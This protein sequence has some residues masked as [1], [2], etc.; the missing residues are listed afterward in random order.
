MKKASCFEQKNYSFLE[1]LGL[2][3]VFIAAVSFVVYSTYLSVVGTLVNSGQS[4]NQPSQNDS[5]GLETTGTRTP[6]G[7][8]VPWFT[9]PTKVE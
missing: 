4:F 6:D 2:L 1:S 9:K 7:L 5:S 8:S 3:S